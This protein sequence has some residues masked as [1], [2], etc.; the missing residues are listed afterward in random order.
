MSQHRSISRRDRSGACGEGV[1]TARLGLCSCAPAACPSLQRDWGSQSHRDMEHL[2]LGGTHSSSGSNPR[3][4]QGS[5]PPDQLAQ[6]PRFPHSPIVF[7][8]MMLL[9]G[10]RHT[11]NTQIP[12]YSLFPCLCVLCHPGSL[13][14]LQS[15]GTGAHSSAFPIFRQR[16]NKKRIIIRKSQTGQ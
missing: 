9:K 7:V 16:E 2:G 15:R 10:C 6:S 4:G 12:Q 3:H 1:L 11:A 8:Q 13:P 5:I 14:S